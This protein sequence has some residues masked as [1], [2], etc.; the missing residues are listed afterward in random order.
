MSHLSS[1]FRKPRVGFWYHSLFVPIDADIAGPRPHTLRNTGILIAVV[2]LGSIIYAT[3]ACLPS[4]WNSLSLCVPMCQLKPRLPRF[5]EG[6]K[7]LIASAWVSYHCIAI[8]RYP[9][10]ATWGREGLL[11]S[12]FRGLILCLLGH[13]CLGRTSWQWGHMVGNHL[14]L[15]VDRKER[16][17]IYSGGK[18]NAKDSP[19]VT[20]IFPLGL[21]PL[22]ASRSSKMVLLPIG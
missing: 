12:C 3:K 7:H 16:D 18:E 19:T 6:I 20:S 17:R 21:E 15:T 2:T 5:L 11:C 13:V 4:L 14:H 9:A 8:I 1:R 10:E 22:K